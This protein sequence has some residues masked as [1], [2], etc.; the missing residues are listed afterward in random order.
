MFDLE[1]YNNITD[2]GKWMDDVMNEMKIMKGKTFKRQYKNQTEKKNESFYRMEK[3]INDTHYWKNIVGDDY[4][5]WYVNYF[6]NR[7]VHSIRNCNM[8]LAENYLDAK[9]PNNRIL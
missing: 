4:L 8:E 2:F 9:H 7:F 1:Y 3:I 6:S 5:N